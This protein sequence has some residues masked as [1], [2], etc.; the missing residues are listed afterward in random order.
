MF[1]KTTSQLTAPPLV[2]DA[3]AGARFVGVEVAGDDVVGV[4]AVFWLEVVAAVAAAAAAAAAF[5]FGAMAGIYDQ[6][7][8]EDKEN[9]L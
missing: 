5:F 4:L 3:A 7:D 8:E 1:W 9:R 6:R 2:V